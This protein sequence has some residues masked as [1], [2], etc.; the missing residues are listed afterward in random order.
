MTDAQELNVEHRDTLLTA[1]ARG[2][3]ISPAVFLGY[4]VD[5][6]GNYFT[7]AS[8]NY[9]YATQQVRSEQLTVVQRDTLLTRKDRE[10]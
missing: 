5:A 8:G 9:I 4:I 7:D 2:T 10:G 3:T 6:S 1:R